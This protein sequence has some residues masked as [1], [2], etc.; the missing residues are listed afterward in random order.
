MECATIN[1]CDSHDGSWGFRRKSTVKARKLHRCHECRRVI[2]PGEEYEYVVGSWE[3]D[4]VS[5]K[6]CTDCVSV[7][8]ELFETYYYGGIR[9][10]LH[11]MI[12]ESDG[13]VNQTC[14]ASMT[15]GGRDMV[16]QMIEDYWEDTPEYDDD[17]NPEPYGD[18]DIRRSEED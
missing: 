15:K 4:I 6:T 2:F 3:G 5:H 17:K 18:E 14:L 7:R 10:G 9:E 1:Q 11:E 16:C 13:D 12:S 8:D